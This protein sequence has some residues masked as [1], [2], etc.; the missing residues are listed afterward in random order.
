MK[1]EASTLPSYFIRR[2]H[3]LF[4]RI[5]HGVAVL[6]AAPEAS[7]GHDIHYRYRPDADLFYLTGFAEPSTV[8][9]FDGEKKELTMFVR[10]KDRERETWEGLRA[11]PKGAVRAFA[12]DHAHEIG[13]LEKRLPELIRK[14]SHLYYSFGIY[15]DGDR[16]IIDA[17]SRFRREARNPERGPIEI[18]DLSSVLHE[19]RLIKDEEELAV[20][21]RSAE[22]TALA[23]EDAMRASRA[24]RMEFELE[25]VVM[26]R[27]LTEGASGPSYHPIV[28]SGANATILHYIE[29]RKRIPEGALLLI[30]AGCEFEGYAADIT[31]TFPVSGRFTEPQKKLYEIVLSAQKAAIAA[32]KPGAR[33]D[34]VQSAAHD[35]LIEGL[36]SVGLLKGKAQ[37]IKKKNLQQQFTL[38]RTSHWLGIDVHD[39][40]RYFDQK[41]EPRIL[42]PGMV[43][44][45]EPGLYV[46]PDEKKVPQEYLGIGIRIEDDVLVTAK[47]N[48]I[49]TAKAPKEVGELE[50]IIGTL[51]AAPKKRK[52]ATP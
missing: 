6:F 33:F 34:T 10:P 42:E 40:G 13:E 36:L 4:D 1:R 9:V 27:F 8:A 3:R 15:P 14:A 28:A 23:H 43:L 19:M 44:T 32:V 16:Q 11:G 37:T 45:V 25:A 5:G 29:N 35:V 7:F 2:H 47:G 31:R 51:P 49:L 24:G 21:R 20:M 41:G 18:T 12:A 52:T 50:A 38:H 46:R 26:N 17:L 30:D 39:R 22:I 48:E